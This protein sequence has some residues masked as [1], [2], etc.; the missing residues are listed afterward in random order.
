MD[1]RVIRLQKYLLAEK[2][3]VF[4]RKVDWH[5]AANGTP[6][7]FRRAIAM[8]KVLAAETPCF[9]PDKRI[10][11][12][13]TVANLPMLFTDEEW[14]AMRKAHSFSEQGIPFNFTPDYPTV[15]ASGLVGVRK[16]AA[17]RLEQCREEGDAAGAQFLHAGI[18]SIDAVLAFAEKYRQ[19]AEANGLTEI[20]ATLAQ[21]PRHGAKTLLEAM[22]SFRIL[23]YALW[24]EGEIPQ[25]RRTT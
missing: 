23:H 21:V 3:H 18:Q 16:N 4:R 25:R 7:V 22:Q 11:G 19:A 9:L 14:A 1:H 5:L 10:A 13:R 12:L 8:E 24:C 15:I 2:H 6:P 17:A 20:A